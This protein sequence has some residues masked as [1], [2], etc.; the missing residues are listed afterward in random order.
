MQMQIEDGLVNLGLAWRS[1]SRSR[2]GRAGSSATCSRRLCVTSKRSCERD[3]IQLDAAVAAEEAGAGIFDPKHFAYP[4]Y[5]KAA[6]QRRDNPRRSIEDLQL[7]LE[8]KHDSHH[9]SLL[10]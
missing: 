4:C 1:R 8:T 5:A 6:A 10:T 7:Q 3:S 9:N 2:Q